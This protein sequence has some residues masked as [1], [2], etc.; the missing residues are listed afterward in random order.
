MIQNK[1]KINPRHGNRNAKK[2]NTN[3][4][5]KNK[6]SG[7]TCGNDLSLIFKTFYKYVVVKNS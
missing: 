6:K 5:K 7:K 1:D 4:L 2:S 3:K